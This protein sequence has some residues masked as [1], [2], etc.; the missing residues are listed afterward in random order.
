MYISRAMTAATLGAAKLVPLQ[1]AHPVNGGSSSLTVG[2]LRKNVLTTSIAG[3][4]AS[5]QPPKF[6]NHA[7]SACPR[8]P[9]PTTSA[10]AAGKYFRDVDWLP[11]AATPRPSPS[12]RRSAFAK[13][14]PSSSLMYPPR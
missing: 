12:S 13:N 5:T 4:H 8:P 14:V 10:I 3:A 11:A 6:V 1:R 2:G 7:L 9:T